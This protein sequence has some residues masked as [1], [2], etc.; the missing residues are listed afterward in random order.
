M[1]R[2]DI[3]AG[4]AY[5]SLYVKKD[6]FARGIQ[7]ARRSIGE[8]GSTLMSAGAKV[9][10]AGSAILGPLTAAVKLASDFE[11]AFSK[12]NFVFNANSVAAKQWADSFAEQVGRSRLQIVEFM[13][14]T[15]ALVMPIG[16]EANTATEMSKQLTQLA[17]DLASFN[18][19][20]D[21]DALRD[22]HAALVGSSETM[23]KY[24]VIANEAAVKTELLNNA[25]DPTTATNQ[26]KVQARYNIIM[27][28]T[29][30]AQGDATRT[31]GSLA[32]QM[33]ALRGTL[34]DV[35]VEVGT[36]VVPAIS[37]LVENVVAMIRPIMTLAREN[38]NVVVSFLAISSAVVASGVALMA[39]GAAAK[40][41]AAGIAVVRVSYSA[42]A[43]GMSIAWKAATIAFSV[44]TI[45]AT[46]AAAAAGA[47]WRVASTVVM[48]A[49]K[50]AS[51]VLGAVFTTVTWVASAALIATTWGTA[52]AAIAIAIF[53]LGTVLTTTAA[54]A[55]TAWGAAGGAVTTAWVASAG[56]IGGIWT[57]LSGSLAML[58]GVAIGSWVSGAGVLGT[59]MA[60]LG[61]VLGTAGTASAVSAALAGAAWTAA[62]AVASA[63]WSGFAAVLTASIAPATLLTIA[64]FAVQTA[65]AAAWAVVSGPLLPFLALIGAVVVGVGGFAAAVAWVTVRATDFSM[66]LGT[67]AGMLSQIMEVA[68]T[69]GGVL[70]DALGGGDYDIAMSAAFAGIKLALA[71]L[72]DGMVS[73]WGQFW[74]GAWNMVKSFFTN[75]VTMT[76]KIITAIANAMK[77]PLKAA[78]GIKKAL[79]DITSGNV[80][81]GI[82]IDTAGMRADATAEIERLEK[83][84]EARKAK[85][86]AEAKAKEAASE[87]AAAGEPK[88]AADK[89]AADAEAAAADEEAKKK[90]DELAAAFDRETDSIQQ[91]I[92]A[93]R[94]GADAAERYRL[95]KEG[96]NDTQIAA[97][98]TQRAE[99]TRL[100][101]ERDAQ[102]LQISRMQDFADAD[103]EKNK[104]TPEQA[105]AREKA[106]IQKALTSGAISQPVAAQAMAEADM[107]RAEREHQERL[108]KFKG[109]DEPAGPGKTA[110]KSSAAVSNLLA[111]QMSSSSPAQKQI[112]LAEQHGKKLDRQIA[113]N[114]LIIMAI[115]KNGL[116]HA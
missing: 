25:I 2:A 78:S 90:A 106:A 91:Q 35:A 58:A 5:V 96:L 80:E 109:E 17:I 79:T 62:G 114:D 33:K 32:N 61:A 49:W 38:P 27:R 28:D 74:S 115:G 73:L 63:A 9:A 14:D 104:L 97:I 46:V 68:K 44:L 55:T 108:K 83:E 29:V 82:G 59:A 20:S 101:K 48:A 10:G 39:L 67:A 7:E 34:S 87:Q 57:A 12:F 6:Q 76:W 116:V 84:L 22:L 16:F 75:F 72:I 60:V 50:T 69:V 66:A 110:G 107:R 65:W 26:Q 77:N 41:A 24:G 100:E 11:E 86:E 54:V 88:P 30:S 1:A 8:I 85:R 112:R 3:M 93:L 21:T 113:Q 31:S 37:K 103:Y 47:A 36:A 15:Q 40:V 43:I 45:K 18:N 13:A 98:M 51:T 81:I 53:G 99:Q 92:I 70:M 105:A 19:T 42:A 95:A 94:D 52:A 111:L 56:V 89:A 4:R 64:A 102:Q 23:L 71:V